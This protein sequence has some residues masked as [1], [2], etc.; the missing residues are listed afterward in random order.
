MCGVTVLPRNIQSKIQIDCSMSKHM[1][2][3]AASSQNTIVI[4]ESH[5]MGALETT[6]KELVLSFFRDSMM[7]ELYNFYTF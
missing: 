7:N 5:S 4:Y 1:C 2:H 6:V 3:V